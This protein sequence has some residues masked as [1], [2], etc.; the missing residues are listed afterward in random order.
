MARSNPNRSPKATK[1]SDL[2]TQEAPL[3]ATL[4]YSDA[5]TALELA[6]AQLQSP[7]LP[8]EEMAALYQRAQCFAERCE[9][10]LAHV[11][12]TI[13]VWDPQEPGNAP[14]TYEPTR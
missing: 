8:V 5:H 11:E 6:L 12:Q 13:E 10:L 9:Q 1:N 4:S 2:Q 7:D 14:Q 3:A